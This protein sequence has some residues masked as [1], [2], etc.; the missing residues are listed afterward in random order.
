MNTLVS[1][2]DFAISEQLLGSAGGF[3][4]PFRRPVSVSCLATH[5]EEA[6]AVVVALQLLDPCRALEGAAEEAALRESIIW[7]R[8]KRMCPRVNC[9]VVCIVWDS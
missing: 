2:A 6:W 8:M 5:L 1:L 4:L 9:A 3:R 7:W